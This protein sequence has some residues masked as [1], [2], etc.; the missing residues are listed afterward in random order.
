MS[1]HTLKP[2]EACDDDCRI[3][4]VKD[5]KVCPVCYYTQDEAVH[6]GEMSRP[7]QRLVQ[8]YAKKRK[9]YVAHA[10]FKPYQRPVYNH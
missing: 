5:L 4:L 2:C 7:A 3:E 10:G 9:Q 6:F 1:K 8:K